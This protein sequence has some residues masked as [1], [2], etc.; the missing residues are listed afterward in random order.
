[1]TLTVEIE[2]WGDAAVFG[3]VDL[4]ALGDPAAD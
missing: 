2:A 3:G 1:M 4:S